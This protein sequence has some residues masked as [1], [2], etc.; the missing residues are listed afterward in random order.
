MCY[1]DLDFQRPMPS[2]LWPSQFFS[3]F[4]WPFPPWP[5]TLCV[6]YFGEQEE[7]KDKKEKITPTNL[8][9]IHQT[10]PKKWTEKIGDSKRYNPHFTPNIHSLS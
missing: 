9:S 1:H 7:D 10:S 3:D 5:L 4:L 2:D 8:W 6:V